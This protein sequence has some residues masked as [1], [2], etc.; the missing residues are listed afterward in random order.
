[1]DGECGIDAVEKPFALPAL[2]HSLRINQIPK[3]P[4]GPKGLQRMFWAT[5]RKYQ[6][7]WASAIRYAMG[8]NLSRQPNGVKAHVSI[9][10]HRK[11]LLDPD[12]LVSSVKPVVDA[13]KGI[14]IIDDSNRHIDLQ[15]SQ[16]LCRPDVPH[17]I[18]EIRW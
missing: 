8:R 3:S 15:V 17:T 9:C 10:Q 18:I 6:W 14:V 12:N 5:R 7:Q 4:N 1:M 16:K 13:M 11:R 2:R